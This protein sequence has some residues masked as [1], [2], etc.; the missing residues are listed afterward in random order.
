MLDSIHPDLIGGVAAVLTTIAFLPQVI[1]SW[2][3]RSTRD[4][5]L[6]MFLILNTGIVL[7]LIYGLILES[8]PLIYAN[9]VTLILTG[10]ILVLKLR[11][12][13]PR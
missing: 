6:G 9:T 2:R 12:D 1:K 10:T 7:W 5:S 11:G 4:V 13:R 8:R 3:S